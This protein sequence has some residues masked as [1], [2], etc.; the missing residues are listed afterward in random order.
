MTYSVSAQGTSSNRAANKRAEQIGAH[1]SHIT[2]VVTDVVGDNT[3]V[4]C[5]KRN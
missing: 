1:A 2:N 3:R 4:A 5:L